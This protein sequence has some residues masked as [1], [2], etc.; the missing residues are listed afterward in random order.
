M[1]ERLCPICN[2][3]DEMRFEVKERGKTI[4]KVCC[5]ECIKKYAE[6]RLGE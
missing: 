1:K 3:I 2:R 6:Q 5:V 4:V